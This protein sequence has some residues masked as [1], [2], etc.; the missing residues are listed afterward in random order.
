MQPHSETPEE[1]SS[2]R[3]RIIGLGETS[4]HKSY[5]PELQERMEEL[6]RFRALLDEATDLIMVIRIADFQCVDMNHAFSSL[7]GYTCTR[8][9]PKDFFSIFPEEARSRMQ[10][11]MNNAA[12]SPHQE[13]I[14]TVIQDIY[15][16]SIEIE[17]SLRQVTFQ[18]ERFGVIV[19]RDIRD[20]KKNER[21]LHTAQKKLSLIYYLTRNDIKSKTFVVRAYLD[22]LRQIAKHPEETSVIEKLTNTTEQIRRDIEYA[23]TYQDM[24]A[25]E[26]IWQHFND[27]FLYAVSHLPPITIT[28]KT[29]LTGIDIYA[30]LLL[31]KGLMHLMEFIY[32]QGKASGEV[33]V[34]HTESVRGLHIIFEKEGAEILPGNKDTLFLWNPEKNSAQ[35]LFF[36]HEILEITSISIHETGDA[37]TLRFEILVP[38]GGYRFS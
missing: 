19:G 18:T 23:E 31:E 34:S 5:Y 16:A 15:G 17:L 35:N 4:V 29:N 1:L 11:F 7:L 27:I 12:E 21:A 2:L 20:R 6:E 33:A 36:I 32:M 26:P 3:D 14:E 37:H 13:K 22:V 28:R 9:N 38:K 8:R 10:V 25:Q 24:G 30:D